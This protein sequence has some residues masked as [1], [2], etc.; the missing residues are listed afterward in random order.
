MMGIPKLDLKE[1]KQFLKK[2]EG[3]K[4]PIQKGEKVCFTGALPKLPER[5]TTGILQNKQ[6]VNFVKRNI[7]SAQTLKPKQPQEYL[8]D[9]PDGHKSVY[10][11][12]EYIFGKKFGCVPQYL[13]KR[14]KNIQFAED[15]YKN[16]LENKIPLC[17]H[18]SKDE[19]EEM[20]KVFFF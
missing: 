7:K 8:I 14:N 5:P 6:S 15:K 18:L 16:E 1:P 3:V 13:V 12:C 9:C 19:V 20:L 2:D 11:D 4:K 17:K 10:K